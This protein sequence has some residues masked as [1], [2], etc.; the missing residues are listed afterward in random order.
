MRHDE[1]RSTRLHTIKQ[2]VISSMWATLEVPDPRGGAA[3]EHGG[4]TP[5]THLGR[6]E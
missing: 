6:S 4:V 1:L 3:I 5:V 2:P